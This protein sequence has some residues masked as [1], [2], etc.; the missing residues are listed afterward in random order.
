MEMVD[1]FCGGGGSSTGF[2]Q[3]GFVT[4]FAV[5]RAWHA[6]ETF[7]A[8]YGDIVYNYDVSKLRSE[9]ILDKLSEKPTL[10]TASPPCE[11]FTTANNKRVNDP[12][13]RLFDDKVG[14]LMIHAIRLISEL[15]PDF[16]MIENVRGILDG[17]NRDLLR[18]EIVDMGLGEP[19]FNW[20]NATRWGVPSERTRV[21]ISNIN[22]HPPSDA[23]YLTVNDV[24]GDLPKPAYPHGIEYHEY[25]PVSS[26]YRDEMVTQAP[27]HG[28]V[29][30]YGSNQ[31]FQNYIR[32]H[33]NRPAPVVM[34]KSKFVHP[35]QDRILT[36]FEHGRLM[37]FPD[38][39]QYVGTTEQIYDVIGEA[40]PPKITKAIGEQILAKL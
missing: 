27:G 5:D 37:T 8:N 39:Y 19:Y 16:W 25:N 7:K 24:I 33:P 2:H 26:K 28:L 30:F 11:P 35:F 15:D 36:P 4:K 22:L 1:L 40:V 17:E 29:F 9:P 32:L 23:D 34:G 20:I 13:M 38:D 6:R 18:D 21:I 3:A 14:R 10:V 12:Y 31:D